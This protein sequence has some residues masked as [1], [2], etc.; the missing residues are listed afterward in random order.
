MTSIDCLLKNTHIIDAVQTVLE[1]IG[2]KRASEGQD[3][4]LTALYNDLREHGVE[5]DLGSTAHIYDNVLSTKDHPAFTT[6]EEVNRIAGK[7]M[8]DLQR[9]LILREDKTGEKQISELSPK[10]AAV[11]AFT[12]N[13]TNPLVKDET[14]KS[15]LKQMQDTY[16]AYAK[17]LFGKT[18]EETETKKDT[19]HF[20]QI[21]SDAIDKESMGYTDQTTG[22]LNGFDKLHEGAKDLMAKL[23]DEVRG[24]GDEALKEQWKNY[25]QSFADATRTLMLST[26]EGKRVLHEALQSEEGGEYI[27]TLKDGTKITD[28]K[29]L[30][31]KTG[32]IT[33]IKDNAVKALKAA[34]FSEDQANNVSDALQKEYSDMM[35]KILMTDKANQDRKTQDPN[36]IE[37][38]K[39]SIGETVSKALSDYRNYQKLA[40]EAKAAGEDTSTHTPELKFSKKEADAITYESLKNSEYGKE[41]GDGDK[42]IDWKNLALNKPDKQALTKIIADNLINN[43]GVKAADAMEAVN[44]L[45][46]DGIHGNLIED[47]ARHSENQLN[48]QQKALGKEIAPVNKSDMTRLA[49]LHAM[50]IFDGAHD[51]LLHHVLGI[52]SADQQTRKKLIDIFAKKQQLIQQFGSHEFLYHSM[53][54]T[55]QHQ[56]DDLI[57]QNIAE[58]SKMGKIAKAIYDYQQATNGGIIANVLNIGENTISGLTANAG[59]TLS[60]LRQMGRKEGAKIFY[61]MNRTWRNVFTDVVKGGV[62]YGMEGGKFTQ[63]G[64]ASDKLTFRNWDNLNPLDKFRTALTAYAR[65]GLTAM[66]SAY[67]VA[68][69]Q[70]TTMLNLHKALT[71]V[72]DQY[73]RVMARDQANEYLNQ[74]LFGKSLEDAKKQAEFMYQKLN[75]SYDQHSIDRSARELVYANLFADGALNDDTIEAA[76][77][78]AYNVAAIGLGHEGRKDWSSFISGAIAMKALRERAQR[79]YDKLIAN[80]EYDKADWFH[81]GIQSILVNGIFKFAHGIANWVVLRPLTAGIGLLTGGAAKLRGSESIDYTNKKDLERHMERQAQANADINRAWVGLARFALEAGAV[82]L[83]GAFNQEDKE[84]GVLGAGFKGVKHNPI[85]NKAMNKFGA[86]LLSLMYVSYTHQKQKEGQMDESYASLHGFLQYAGNLTNVGQGFSNA[87]RFAEIGKLI[88][89]NSE[90]SKQKAYGLMGEMVRGIVPGSGEVPYYRSFKGIYYLGKSGVQ[91]KAELPPYYS[92][93]SFAQGFFDN[94]I[95]NDIDELTG[96]HLGFFPKEEEQIPVD[97]NR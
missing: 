89:Q 28:W 5:I 43:E 57:A 94:G 40:D 93:Q 18:P 19:R 69:H 9:A 55:L 41:A 35:G 17:K 63:G 84:G 16:I 12:R 6:R 36:K 71:S 38:P 23:N 27:K 67:K 81:I 10:E 24:S 26:N 78:S 30:A 50:G 96:G 65:A 82:G 21:I 60:I 3:A 74:H 14:T 73:G 62:N 46:K 80:E 86:D 83:Y 7:P 45:L 95:L 15:H 66:D 64:R 52:D 20:E 25:Y 31:G 13:F 49:E 47:I 48:A 29:K 44:K 90:H 91:Q 37:K 11:K 72:P 59:Q 33:Q 88:V 68:L 61:E 92:P 56:V 8:E 32:S 85:A 54:A 42:Q 53:D 34:G 58:K 39:I 79:H 76:T 70:K 2:T 1:Y 51:D 4:S 87:E 77:R 22:A 75:M 97:V